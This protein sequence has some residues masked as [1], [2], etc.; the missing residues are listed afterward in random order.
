[1]NPET[2]AVSAEETLILVD[3]NDRAIG[4]AE[5]LEVH[6]SGLLHRAVS[7]LIFN[8]EGKMLLQQRA[9]DKYHSPL[10]WANACCTHPKVGESVQQCAKRRLLEELGIS[11]ELNL[12]FSFVYRADVGNGLVE[13]EYDHVYIGSSDG[14]FEPNP[15]EVASLRFVGKP[16][17]ERDIRLNPKLYCAWF[18]YILRHLDEHIP[19]WPVR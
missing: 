8:S 15:R 2:I 9:A 11:T 19:T 7:V 4:S 3:V 10:L 12:A 16:E 17:L 18:P 5:K 14:P 6:R 13:H 1:L